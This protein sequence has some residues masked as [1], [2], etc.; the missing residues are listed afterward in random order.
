MHNLFILTNTY[1]Y[2]D[3]EQFLESEIEFWAQTNFDN[4][5][6]SPSSTGNTSRPIPNNIKILNRRLISNKYKYLILALMSPIFHKEIVYL[7][8]NIKMK[9]L[10]TCL[11]STVVNT[12]ILLRELEGLRLLLKPFK[13]TK[14][15]IYSYWNDSSSYAACILKKQ[16]LV[17][18]VI[19]RAHGFDVYQERRPANHMPLKR[20]FIDY[21]DKV[22][23][24]A[25]TPLD[26]YHKNYNADLK[27]LDIA[28][29][30]VSLPHQIKTTVSKPNCLRILSLSYCVPV[31]QI[32]LIMSAIHCYAKKYP[33][34]SI[35]WTHIGDGP[36]F[37][38]L[39]SEAQSIMAL[40]NNLK[41]NFI[42]QLKNS[43]VKSN[44]ESNYYDLII[45]A[46]K[47]EGVPVS[48]MEAMSYGIP[49]IAP[50]IGGI[51]DLVNDTNGYIM[52]SICTAEDIIIGIEVIYKNQRNIPYR[53]NARNWIL[54]NFN[55]NI[56]YPNF[57]KK[58]ECISIINK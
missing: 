45:N 52:P 33:S 58:L 12:A 3:G 13:G 5:F 56:N 14:V 15:T 9:D 48:I 17:D 44:L 8:K 24:L 36:L 46:S 55:A 6:I 41:I 2:K 7:S 1:P 32:D 26:Y 47:S 42:G 54:K 10:L 50:N 19:T 18:K 11:K 57:I 30:G 34:N 40:N 31:K 20:Q 22:Y 37:N 38:I 25:K 43:E 28:A 35:I 4:V 21:Y 51:E 29:L 49:A 23:L 16:G 27:H 53:S 39:K